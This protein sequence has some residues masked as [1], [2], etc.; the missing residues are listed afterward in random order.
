MKWR[1]DLRYGIQT[2]RIAERATTGAVILQ[3]RH[4]RRRIVNGSVQASSGEFNREIHS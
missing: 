1:D 3:L 4:V 2:P